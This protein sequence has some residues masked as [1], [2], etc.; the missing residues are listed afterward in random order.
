[1]LVKS[2]PESRDCGG[3]CR[4]AAAALRCATRLCTPNDDP[5]A[6]LDFLDDESSDEPPAVPAVAVMVHAM[7]SFELETQEGSRGGCTTS[8]TKRANGN[9]DEADM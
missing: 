6:G 2:G 8:S 7:H 1:M 4:S 9:A 5:L 3:P